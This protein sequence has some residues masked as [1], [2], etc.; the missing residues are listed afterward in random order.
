MR[1]TCSFMWMRY[2]CASCRILDGF[3]PDLAILSDTGLE[4]RIY[5]SSSDWDRL[6]CRG[7]CHCSSRK[8]HDSSRHL[9]IGIRDS[10]NTI[11][12]DNTSAVEVVVRMES[13][14]SS[15]QTPMFCL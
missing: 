7:Q 5:S 11:E 10:T 9:V 8:V 15:Y 2:R 3:A 13:K 1:S 14:V 12:I 6:L 4:A